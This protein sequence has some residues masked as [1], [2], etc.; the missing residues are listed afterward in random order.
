M[1]EYEHEKELKEEIM[2]Q[3]RHL[4]IYGYKNEQ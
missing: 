3:G 1:E 4:F 2:E